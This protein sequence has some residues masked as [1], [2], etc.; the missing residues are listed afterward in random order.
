MQ[1]SFKTEISVPLFIV[2]RRFEG[3]FPLRYQLPGRNQPYPIAYEA[4][5]IGRT[6]FASRADLE[7]VGAIDDTYRPDL[8]GQVR[9]GFTA[10]SITFYTPE[11][12]ALGTVHLS[13]PDDA[14]GWTAIVLAPN[15]ALPESYYECWWFI[16]EV[17][18]TF[19]TQLR[20][21]VERARQNAAIAQWPPHSP[22]G[23]PPTA[24]PL[25]S[26]RGQIS[27]SPVVP[28]RR[29]SKGGRPRSPIDDWAWEQ[30]QVLG[31][32]RAVV[33]AEWH[34]RNAEV[35]RLLSDPERSFK[36]AIAL[37]RRHPNDIWAWE[38]VNLVKRSS[39]DVFAEWQQRNQQ[40]ER[41]ITDPKQVF[42]FVIA[43]NQSTGT[44]A[45]G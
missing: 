44:G 30:I 4:V 25:G 41:M 26:E 10:I 28:M 11:H 13:V 40:Q 5:G 12:L 24:K 33:Y 38:Q 31:R 19:A 15:G 2:Y 45:S 36:H 42:A 1:I 18:E 7:A 34:Q 43:P 27:T 37:Q 6:C 14:D 20:V 35:N 3:L 8:L 16:V 21:A 9:Y 22:E 17:I 23:A 29:Q 39:A 32:K